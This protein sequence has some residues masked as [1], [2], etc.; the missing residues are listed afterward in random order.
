[1]IAFP[2]LW[3]A[4]QPRQG[5]RHVLCGLQHLSLACCSSFVYRS[6]ASRATLAELPYLPNCHNNHY[7]GDFGQKKALQPSLHFVRDH[8][9]LWSI[10]HIWPPS[11]H[12]QCLSNA[13]WSALH[14]TVTCK[15]HVARRK[16]HVPP[17]SHRMAGVWGKRDIPLISGFHNYGGSK[18]GDS[19]FGG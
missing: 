16:P 6:I 17:T 11:R 15:S 1:M 9:N 10:I 2:H 8:H 12:I 18:Y 14:M 5:P 7:Y 4:F 13:I 19:E 3:K